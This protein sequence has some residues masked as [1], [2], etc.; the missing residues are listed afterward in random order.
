MSESL[1][2]SDKRTVQQKARKVL[3][4]WSEIVFRSIFFWEND[5]KRLGILIRTLHQYF[6]TFV[7]LCYILVHTVLPSYIFMFLIWI[8]IGCLA[9]VQ[10][11]TGCCIWTRIEQ[12]LIGDKITLSDYL[13]ELFHIPITKE[14]TIGVTLM[15]STSCFIFLSFELFTRTLLNITEFFKSYTVYK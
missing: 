4:K 15:Y 8:I 6:I 12:R 7:V 14:N 13:L 10:L 11:L 1:H 9:F 2:L 5:D 3:E